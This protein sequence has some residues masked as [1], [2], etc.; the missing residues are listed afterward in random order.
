MRPL[1]YRAGGDPPLA[2]GLD[3]GYQRYRTCGIYC[4]RMR[5]VGRSPYSYRVLVKS[6]A[7][8]VRSAVG[9]WWTSVRNLSL[10]RTARRF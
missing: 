4:Y 5:F 7:L 6:I 10:E 8:L 9:C 2:Y 1:F 3:I